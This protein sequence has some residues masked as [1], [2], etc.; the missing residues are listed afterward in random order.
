VRLSERTLKHDGGTEV[1][2][3]L[4]KLDIEALGFG[5][6]I[7]QPAGRGRRREVLV[8]KPYGI[9]HLSWDW[10]AYP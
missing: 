8:V 9:E 3:E 6:P 5:L 4:D 10:E 7:V 2:V 1:V